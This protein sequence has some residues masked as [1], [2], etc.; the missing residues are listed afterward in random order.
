[1]T[2]NDNGNEKEQ[3]APQ[4]HSAGRVDNEAYLCFGDVVFRRIP[5]Q[6]AASAEY[7]VVHD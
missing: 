5:Q 7:H 1:M 3:D 2:V 6:P 4:L